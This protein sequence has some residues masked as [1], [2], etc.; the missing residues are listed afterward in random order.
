M[1]KVVYENAPGDIRVLRGQIVGNSDLFLSLR[2]ENGDIFEINKKS[3]QKIV[4][5]GDENDAR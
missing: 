5:R 4:R 3:I 1:A 2:M